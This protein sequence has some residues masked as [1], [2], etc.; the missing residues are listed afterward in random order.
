MAD[1]K[2]CDCG[3]ETR[4]MPDMKLEPCPECQPKAYKNTWD[5]INQEQRC[6]K[7]EN[8]MASSSLALRYRSLSFD[9]FNIVEAHKQKMQIVFDACKSYADNFEQNKKDGK[10][11]VL[12]GP[13]GTGKGHLAAAIANQIMR[14]NL[15]SV[16]FRKYIELV[17][18]IK[19]SW[20]GR[21]DVN[22]NQIIAAARDCDLL[23]LDEIGLQFETNAEKVILYRI[24]DGRYENVMPLIITTNLNESQLLKVVGERVLDRIYEPPSQILIL[25][26]P[27]YRRGSEGQRP[28]EG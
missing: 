1:K 22:E 19:E 20:H 3:R 25:N 24:I 17:S 16:L 26:W 10:W 11:L 13:C 21:T 12:I 4:Y 18:K 8:L 23:I 27:S 14:D 6:K 2:S 5:E 28:Q 15:G 7:I 9:N